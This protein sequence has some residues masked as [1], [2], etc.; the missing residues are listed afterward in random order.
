MKWL[1]TDLEPSDFRRVTFHVILKI[2]RDHVIVKGPLSLV[3]AYGY[4]KMDRERKLECLFCNFILGKSDGAVVKLHRSH[5][6]DNLP[7]FPHSCLKRLS[8]YRSFS[9]ADMHLLL[10]RR[11]QH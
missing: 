11:F 1:R 7:E 9:D 6:D 3:E 8:I 5:N 10:S 4:F 2:L